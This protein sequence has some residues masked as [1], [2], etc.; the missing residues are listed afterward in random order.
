MSSAVGLNVT[1]M[2]SSYMTA[3]T[4]KTAAKETET[5]QETQKAES[6]GA[7]YDKTSSEN[8]KKPT[9][10]I[11]KMSAER[12]AQ[13]VKQM[14]ADQA[15][16][17]NQLASIVN[18]MLSRQAGTA[19]KAEG[20]DIWKILAKGNLRDVA[21]DD[22][23]QAQD[24]ISEDGYYGVKQTSKR[25]FD[26]ASALAG[27]DPEKMEEMRKAFEKGF[28]QATKAWGQELPGISQDTYKAVE[29]MFDDYADSKKVVTEEA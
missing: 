16:R 25:I 19:K 28:K 4:S 7:V 23:L 13:I 8:E 12:R 18:K 2:A 10:S 9:Y 22:I 1:S 24:D 11:N 29:K 21:K 6:A 17:Q 3:D 27:D 26:F 20:D 14:K 15:E 5:K